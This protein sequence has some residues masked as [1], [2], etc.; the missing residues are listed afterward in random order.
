MSNNQAPKKEAPWLVFDDPK[1]AL[2]APILDGAEKKPTLK[3]GI[4]ENNPRLRVR[5]NVANDKNN[6]YIDAAMDAQRFW[7]MLELVDYVAEHQGAVTHFIDNFGHP[8][9]NGGRSK[10]P[11]IVSRTKIQKNEEGVVSITLSAG[12][13]RP[14]PEFVLLDNEYHHFKN[15]D[16]QSMPR[17]LASRLSALAWT[18]LIRDVLGPELS[19]HTAK[20]EWMN[21]NQGGGGGGYQGNN[22]GGGGYQQNRGGG[23]GYQQ[24]GGGQ[25]RPQQQSNTM[26]FDDDI[27]M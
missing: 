24:Q 13:S 4:F 14:A 19:K 25:Q 11:V 17:A 26:D 23:G 2:F 1:M 18:K 22:N 12:K 10:E 15:G 27:P 21:R 3:V 20:P 7:A 16:G 6:G 5:T 9:M 8:W